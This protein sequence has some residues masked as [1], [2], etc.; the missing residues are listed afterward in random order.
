MRFTAF[1][2]P[3]TYFPIFRSFDS[4]SKTKESS[5]KKHEI[6][7]K[8]NL[9]TKSSEPEGANFPSHEKVL[10]YE[11]SHLGEG[12]PNYFE[13]LTSVK[14]LWRLVFV[15][16]LLIISILICL[17]VT[18]DNSVDSWYYNLYKPD[19]APDGI[20]IV[21]IYSFLSLLYVWCW[22]TVS[23]NVK[24]SFVDLAFIGFY[25]LFTLWFIMLFKYQNLKAGRI[26]M[27]IVTGYV[28]CLFIYSAFFLKI[29]SVSL[30]LFLFLI[31][32]IVLIVYSYQLQD[33][34]K[35]YSVL[36]LAKKGTSLYKKKIRLEMVSGIKVDESG[37][38]VEF[39][40]DDQ[41]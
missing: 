5:P 9:K 28:A 30:Y 33:L 29:G 7:E 15:L 24:N 4:E 27:D 11:N 19:W 25:V 12:E 17:N 14:F 13:A 1:L 2:D 21:I 26:I 20:T 6:L 36:G 10:K 16:A 3:E 31:W 38:K 18:L 39:N 32:S 23:K 37:N 35:E 34:S 40:P 22:Y 41:E 8:E